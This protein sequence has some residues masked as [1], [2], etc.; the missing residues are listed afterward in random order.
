MTPINWFLGWVSWQ[1]YYHNL[2]PSLVYCTMR[3][4]SILLYF[5]V[6]GIHILLTQ[7]VANFWI[8]LDTWI[9]VKTFKVS[10]LASLSL[11]TESDKNGI[12]LDIRRGTRSRCQIVLGAN[13]RPTSKNSTW[14]PRSVPNVMKWKRDLRFSYL[15]RDL[16][17]RRVVDSATIEKLHIN[18]RNIRPFCFY[19]NLNDST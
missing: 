13:T 1:G 10:L 14:Y 17:V 8:D 4:M 16:G 9:F 15:F 5:W 2:T 3:Q 7:L 18:R 19:N 6:A 12:V 11:Y